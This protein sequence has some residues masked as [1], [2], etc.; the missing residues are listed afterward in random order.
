MNHSQKKE[1]YLDYQQRAVE[2]NVGDPVYLFETGSDYVGRVVQVYRGIG[3]VDVQFP[4]GSKRL[5]VESLQRLAV[6]DSGAVYADPPDVEHHSIPGGMPY[7]KP[8]NVSPSMSAIEQQKAKPSAIKKKELDA[9]EEAIEEA[10]AAKES[11][12]KT[13]GRELQA[14]Y[15]ANRD[16]QYRGTK[17]ELE[18]QAFSC[19]KCSEPLRRANYKRI[20]GTP[21]HLLCCRNCLFLIE[22]EDIIG[23][24]NYVDV[25]DA[26]DLP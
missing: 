11:I 13:A 8:S 10:E 15:W 1:A 24:P 7:V 21:I 25:G 26:L 14:L 2:F 4:A 22:T 5:P 16:R 6:N 9:A 12:A 20:N 19:P 3:M 18:T 17:C 23:H